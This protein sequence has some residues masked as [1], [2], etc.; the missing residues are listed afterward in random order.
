MIGELRNFRL[1]V[2]YDGTHLSGFQQQDNARTVQGELLSALAL[3]N[4]K[5]EKFTV[6][7]R[8]DA[9]VH[10][11]G[12][13]VSIEL[14]SK[15][16]TRQLLLAL[17][18]KLPNDIAVWRIDEMSLGFDARRHSVGKCYRYTIDQ[19]LVA[20]PFGRATSLHVR[21]SLDTIAMSEAASFLVGDHDFESFRSSGCT[22]AHARR[23]IWHLS[24][25][26]NHHLIE[27]DIRG[28]AFCLN[29]VRIMVGTLIE[30]GKGKKKPG[31]VKA[32]LEAKNRR[33]AGNTAR[34]HGLSLFQVYY[35]DDL[36]DAKIPSSARFPRFP[37]TSESWP[38]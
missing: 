28:N 23:Y 31:D 35:P 27:V 10:A 34:A 8:T 36:T 18:T 6:A 13:S 11:H 25:T 4:H 37:V 20:K 29:M 22:A 33:L 26:P 5:P 2:S 24:V 16:S 38:F 1:Y 15:L 9:G 32:I 3:I 14:V 19:S 7:G 17:A 30:V 12:Q 21:S